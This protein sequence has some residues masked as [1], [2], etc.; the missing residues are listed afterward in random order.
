MMSDF[1]ANSILLSVLGEGAAVITHRQM[2]G[3][4]AISRALSAY[5]DLGGIDTRNFAAAMVPLAPPCGEGTVEVKGTSGT[6]C[7]GIFDNPVVGMDTYVGM[8]NQSEHLPQ[9]ILSGQVGTLALAVWQDQRFGSVAR[10]FYGDSDKG[11]EVFSVYLMIGLG[12]VA[13]NLGEPPEWFVG[14]QRVDQYLAAKMGGQDQPTGGDVVSGGGSSGGG[15]VTAEE[16]MSTGAKVLA[17]L[18]IAGLAL[19]IAKVAKVI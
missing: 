16:G 1:Q 3:I 18:A 11:L 5:G 4:L 6:A 15:S 9:A 13:K 7:F 19:G 12:E 2:Q 14:E 17:G 8:L 10:F